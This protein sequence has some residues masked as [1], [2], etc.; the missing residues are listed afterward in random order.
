MD[1]PTRSRDFVPL[2]SPEPGPRDLGPL[3]AVVVRSGTLFRVWAPLAGTVELAIDRPGERPRP[4]NRQDDGYWEKTVTDAPPGTLYRYRLD[5]ERQLPDPASRLQTQGVHGPSSVWS[6]PSRNPHPSESM[7]PFRGHALKDLIFYELHVGTFSG[8]ST[9]KGVIRGLDHLADLGVTALELMPLSQFPGERNWGYDGV[10][11]YAIQMSYGGPDGLRDLVRAC[12]ERHLSVFLDV[13]TNHLGPEGNYLSA[14][15]P[16]FSR[17][18]STPWGEALNFD[19]SGSDHVRHFFLEN[20]RYLARTFD[21]DGFRFDAVHAIRDQSAHPFLADMSVIA[22]RIAESRGRPLHL[23]AESNLNDRRHVMPPDKGGMGFDAQWSDD[24]HHAVHVTFTGEKDGYYADFSGGK[25]V[26]RAMAGGFV[27]QGQ[28]AP[29]FR[30]RRGSPSG[31]LPG[32][33]FIVFAQNHDQVGNRREGD[34]LSSR[35]TE[36]ALKCV[37]ALVILSPAL[38]LLFMGEEY[39]ETR[40]FQFFTS[41]GDPDLIRAVREGRAREFAAFGWKGDV[42]DPQDVRTFEASRLGRTLASADFSERE[43]RILAFTR[44]LI[45]L[46]K[47]L[48]AFSP[49][50]RMDEPFHR[51]RGPRYGILAHLRGGREKTRW[52]VLWNL[53]GHERPLPE[54]WLERELG[55]SGSGRVLLDSH[56]GAS[57]VACRMAPW[58]VLVQEEGKSL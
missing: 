54:P 13:V 7:A 28:Y 14:Y 1:D 8:L 34:R 51:V 49:P 3:G 57:P 39:G 38:P 31:D 53:T 17:T 36:A 40:P 33:S 58:Q 5:G 20:M 27:Y 15:G 4:M 35:L 52:L 50:E 25:D 6:P 19:A 11:P 18:T 46:R 47:S 42:P 41:H 44:K 21:V 48:P 26:A 37:A 12:H 45:R 2:S 10:Y 32:Q 29:S 23:V 56:E 9:F 16:Y 30:H 55:W 22:S 24:F 43:S